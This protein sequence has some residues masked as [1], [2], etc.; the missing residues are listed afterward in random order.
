MYSTSNLSVCR[1]HRAG[2]SEMAKL[3][4]IPRRRRIFLARF[5]QALE[6]SSSRVSGYQAIKT[7]ELI[8]KPTKCRLAYGKLKFRGHM[9]SNGG[10][11]PD[12]EETRAVAAF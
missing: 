8:L 1:G 11:R 6:I 3:P 10:V 12:S 9:V 2:S 4:R 7:A 5:Q